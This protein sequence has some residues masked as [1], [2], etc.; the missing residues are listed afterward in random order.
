MLC[1]I[2]ARMNG[3]VSSFGVV[4]LLVFSV[5]PAPSINFNLTSRFDR[6]EGQIPQVLTSLAHSGVTWTFT[7]TVPAVASI[8]KKST[9]ACELMRPSTVVPLAKIVAVA[10]VLPWSSGMKGMKPAT[11]TRSSCALVAPA[12]SPRLH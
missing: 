11:T 7:V 2:E 5:T 6:Q 3:Q 9:S 10:A 8:R 1:T 4:G 12:Y